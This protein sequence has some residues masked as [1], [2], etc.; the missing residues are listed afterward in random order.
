MSMPEDR[1]VT[2]AREQCASPG[3]AYVDIDVARRLLAYAE[4]R[5]RVNVGLIAENTELK[6]KIAALQ[7]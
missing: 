1:R 3:A 4:E 2:E 6:R 7:G 5:L